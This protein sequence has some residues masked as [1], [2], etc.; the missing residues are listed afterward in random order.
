MSDT[1]KRRKATRLTDLSLNEV[2]GVD[3]PAHLNDGWMVLKSAGLDDES[4]AFVLD[5]MEEAER[6]SKENSSMNKPTY[7]EL[8]A[9]LA[10]AREDLAKAA[11]PDCGM[12][13]CDCDVAKSE[14]EDEILKALPEPVRKRFVELEQRAIAAEETVAKAQEREELSKSTA[15]LDGIENLPG[16]DQADFAKHYHAIRKSHPEAAQAV[17]QVL[18]AA[19]AE[20]GGD[21]LLAEVGK[22]FHGT[23]GDPYDQL[24]TLAHDRVAKGLSPDFASAFDEV[25]LSPE[26]ATLYDEYQ[27]SHVRKSRA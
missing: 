10:K 21:A 27:K 18:K 6:L 25:L 24:S 1:D 5:V 12:A 23:S 11:C 22:S 3:R 26:G 13:K 19:D 17:L 16:F 4:A 2:S 15:D 14:S 7:E 8:E 20:L 9:E